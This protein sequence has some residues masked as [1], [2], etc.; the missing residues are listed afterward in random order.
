MCGTQEPKSISIP[1]RRVVGR[2]AVNGEVVKGRNM[3]N[4][5]ALKASVLEG[6]PLGC[7]NVHMRTCVSPNL[8]QGAGL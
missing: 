4:D 3:G 8:G 5:C 1:W 7:E 2:G 6:I